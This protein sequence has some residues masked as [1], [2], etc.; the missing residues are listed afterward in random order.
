MTADLH[1]II[2]LIDDWLNSSVTL[3]LENRS[4][5]YACPS[6]WQTSPPKHYRCRIRRSSVIRPI[7]IKSKMGYKLCI[8]GRQKPSGPQ[9]GIVHSYFSHGRWTGGCRDRKGVK[10]LNH[11]FVWPIR[12]SWEPIQVELCESLLSTDHSKMQSESAHGGCFVISGESRCWTCPDVN[13][14][15]GACTRASTNWVGCLTMEKWGLITCV[16]FVVRNFVWFE[17]VLRRRIMSQIFR[18]HTEKNSPRLLQVDTKPC[19]GWRYN[20]SVSIPV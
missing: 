9:I 3:K 19:Q 8:L 16:S 4:S 13:L 11:K 5:L 12:E 20:G 10:S 17:F 14:N 7:S 15:I 2:M 1:S 18:D 6:R